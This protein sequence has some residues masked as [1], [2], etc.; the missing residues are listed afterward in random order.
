MVPADEHVMDE[1]LMPEAEFLEALHEKAKAGKALDLRGRTVHLYGVIKLAR[2][3]SAVVD[4]GT[5]IGHGHS[6]F[7]I[8][9]DRQ[10]GPPALTLRSVT[11]LHL[12]E[13]EEK[14]DI[15][16]AVFVMGRARV[17][18][19]ECS[20]SSIGGFALWLKHDASVVIVSSKLRRAGRT[21][22]ACFNRASLTM[23]DC[24]ISDSNIHGICL[25]GDASVSLE[26]CSIG[27]LSNP[28][29]FLST[30]F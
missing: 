11:L 9:T 26:R 3:E 30:I 25:R 5:L 22:A 18:I 8:G 14:K 19:F 13:S 2:S 10:Q 27:Q 28:C 21:G 23:S 29:W 1:A 17:E 4:G 16:A 24:S 20:L 7:S 15:G 12:L 6:I